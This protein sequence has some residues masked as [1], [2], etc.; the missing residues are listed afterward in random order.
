[1]VR[2]HDVAGEAARR[3]E[4]C[5]PTILG[6]QRISRK[7]TIFG[8][9]SLRIAKDTSSAILFINRRCSP[10]LVRNAG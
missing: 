8:E 3:A 7:Q 2:S 4:E 1:M 9:V 6:R 5:D 10:K